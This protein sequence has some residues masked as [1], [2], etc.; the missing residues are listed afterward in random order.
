M[1]IAPIARDQQK[2]LQNIRR[3]I[4]RIFCDKGT[5]RIG[6]ACILKGR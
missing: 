2:G 1:E 5:D 3:E 4:L 6:C